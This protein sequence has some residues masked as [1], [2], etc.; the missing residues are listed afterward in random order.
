MAAVYE[1]IAAPT[2][3]MAAPATYATMAAPQYTTAAP[4]YTQAYTTAAPQYTT[5]AY[6]TAAPQYTTA[7]VTAAPSYVA[8]PMMNS[9]VLGGVSTG[10]I[11]VPNAAPMAPP[12]LTTGIPTPDMIA[13]AKTERAGQLEKQL[14]EA[15]G[16]VQKETQIEKDMAKFSA[17]KSI[18]LFNNEMEERLAEAIAVAEEQ[19]TITALE[20]KKALTERTLQLNAKAESLRMD[21]EMKKVQTECAQKRY[22]FET[23]FMGAETKL[24]EEYAKQVAIANTG[25]AIGKR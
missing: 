24:A 14:K 23:E 1:T 17:D 5:Q 22:K 16:T 10:G 8:A 6:T 19:A 25:T 13:K 4:Q 9:Q 12:K 11:A 2:T 15:I 18:A 3:V 21:Y 20:L 7:Q